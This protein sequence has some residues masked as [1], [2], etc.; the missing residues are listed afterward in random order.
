MRRALTIAVDVVLGVVLLVVSVYP[1]AWLLAVSLKSDREA[2][3]MPTQ[4]IF[5]PNFDNYTKLLT[6]QT[7]V[8][9]LINSLQLTIFAT[10]LCVLFGALAAYGLSRYKMRGAATV[11]FAFAITRLVP[12]FAIVI[13]TFYMYRQFNLLDTMAGLV[14]AL[15]AFQV[16]LSTLVMYRVLDGIPMSLD[17]AARLDGASFLRTFWEVIMPIARPGLAASAVV[18][19][20]L[21][22]NEF[23]FVLV[24]AG[25]K[26]MTMPMLISTF[27]TD[28]QILW[29]SI[30]AASTISLVPILLIVALAQKHL[31]SGLGMGSVR[32]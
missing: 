28:K 14:L 21:V 5:V 9:A 19:F 7:F 3:E 30:A 16:P 10:A 11:T 32:E 27:Q 6:N 18:T 25:N 22:W 31:L 1:V 15:V 2:Y 26:V 13:P 24:L 8:N 17:E 4:W 29:G 23:L 20:I 12:T